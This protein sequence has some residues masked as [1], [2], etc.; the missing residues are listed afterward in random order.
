MTQKAVQGLLHVQGSLY[1]SSMGRTPFNFRLSDNGH[2]FLGTQAE[3][4]EVTMSDVIRAALRI[5]ANHP[6]ELDREIERER[7]EL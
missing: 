6:K 4:H 1:G 7:D 3:R 2:T 5:A